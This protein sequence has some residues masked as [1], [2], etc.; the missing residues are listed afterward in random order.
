VREQTKRIRA[1]FADADLDTLIRRLGKWR[2]YGACFVLDYVRALDTLTDEIRVKIGMWLLLDWITHRFLCECRTCR[3]D[4]GVPLARL[5]L[6]RKDGRTECCR[7]LSISN[8]APFRR[9]L[10]RD[11]MP[12]SR[13][14]IDL[15]R[16]FG[17]RA[18]DAMAA[19]RREAI[20]VKRIVGFEHP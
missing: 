7:P 15:T 16:W 18:E 13:S 17:A 3:T 8:A 10:Q 9:E 4:D 14:K 6:W 20:P 2:L 5:W 11:C 19:M 1:L 12:I